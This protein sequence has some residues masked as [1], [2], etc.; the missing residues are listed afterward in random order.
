MNSIRDLGFYHVVDAVFMLASLFFV[1]CLTL[2]DLFAG[3]MHALLFRKWD[4]NVKGRDWYDMEWYIQ[5]GTPLNLDHFAIRAKDSG[6]WETD[7]ITEAEFR[8]LL[9]KKIDSVNLEYIKTDI[10]R[11]LSDQRGLEIWSPK[12]FHELTIHL[13][14]L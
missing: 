13:G 5:R 7:S 9:A 11:F 4:T 14:V 3:K 6:D 2:P 10:K 12:Y 8:V 1:K